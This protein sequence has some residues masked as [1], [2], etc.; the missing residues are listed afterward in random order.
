MKLN[1]SIFIIFCLS[2]LPFALNSCDSDSEKISDEQ[3][4]NRIIDMLHAEDGK[5]I[6]PEI[7]GTDLRFVGFQSS[8]IARGFV[9]GLLAQQWD[10]KKIRHLR[11][12]RLRHTESSLDKHLTGRRLRHN[13]L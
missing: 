6:F 2:L 9:F 12:P 8:D 4:Y 5:D 1:S 11:F 7:S 3:N 13:S 10:G